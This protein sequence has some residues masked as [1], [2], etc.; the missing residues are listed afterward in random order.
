[1]ELLIGEFMVS[2]GGSRHRDVH[3]V[4]CILHHFDIHAVFGQDRLGIT[5]EP[6]LEGFILPARSK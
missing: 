4:V 1:M 3:A 6:S 2:T 5:H